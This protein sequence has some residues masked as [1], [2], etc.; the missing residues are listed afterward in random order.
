[1]RLLSTPRDRDEGNLLLANGSMV[2]KGVDV[3]LRPMARC[4]NARRQ[5]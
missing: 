4:A 3:F 1:M 2:L 5:A